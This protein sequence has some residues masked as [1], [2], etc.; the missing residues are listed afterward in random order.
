MHPTNRSDVVEGTR[1][2]FEVVITDT[3][4]GEV[5]ARVRCRGGVVALVKSPKDV[6]TTFGSNGRCICF[7]SGNRLIQAFDAFRAWMP[8]VTKKLLAMGALAG[9]DE[10]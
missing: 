6:D 9:W 5:F 7:G 10:D 8:I 4:T 1:S 2:R 3:D